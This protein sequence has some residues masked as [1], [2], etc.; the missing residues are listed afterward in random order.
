MADNNRKLLTAVTEAVVEADIVAELCALGASGYTITDAR[1]S[2]SRG[3][4]D[5]GWSTSA[6]IRIEVVCEADTAQRIAARLEERF[7]AHYAMVV[8]ISEVAVLRPDKFT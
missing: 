5:G 6:N 1:G 8:Y 7:Y 4:R 3:L 2:G